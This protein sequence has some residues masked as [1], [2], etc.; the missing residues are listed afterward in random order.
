MHSIMRDRSNR[1]TWHI[2]T[3]CSVNS[4]I[5]FRNHWEKQKNIFPLALKTTENLTMHTY[6]IVCMHNICLYD[7]RVSTENEFC[8]LERWHIDSRRKKYVIRDF[9][10]IPGKKP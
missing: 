10:M 4:N 5:V 6:S 2:V 9:K 8:G 7:V 1:I 3:L